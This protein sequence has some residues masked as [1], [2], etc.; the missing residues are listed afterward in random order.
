MIISS[1]KKNTRNQNTIEKNWKKNIMI[2]TIKLHWLRMAYSI[3]TEFDLV[4]L[5]IRSEYDYDYIYTISVNICYEKI[6][7]CWVFKYNS[8]FPLKGPLNDWKKLLQIIE[9]EEEEEKG[10]KYPYQLDLFES[11]WWV[12]WVNKTLILEHHKSE[13]EIDMTLEI[14]EPI[15]VVESI[16]KNMEEVI[17]II[18]EKCNNYENSKYY[19][20]KYKQLYF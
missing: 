6:N 13:S 7:V 8:I 14:H 5:V 18:Q 20:C 11:D 15:L 12:I 2:F 3:P 16:I 4:N 10:D 9:V 17:N 1:N 19:Y